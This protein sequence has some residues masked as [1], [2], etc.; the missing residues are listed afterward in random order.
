MTLPACSRC[1]SHGS[2]RGR[3]AMSLPLCEAVSVTLSLGQSLSRPQSCLSEAL[4]TQCPVAPGGAAR[5]L[6]VAGHPCRL[7]FVTWPLLCVP[8]PTCPSYRTP[9]L[10]AGPHMTSF[11]LHGICNDPVSNKVPCTVPGPE[12]HPAHGWLA[13]RPPHVRA[14]SA[15]LSTSGLR[16]SSSDP[17]LVSHPLLLPLLLSFKQRPPLHVT[18]LVQTSRPTPH[19]G[20]TWTCPGGAALW[21][22][23][24]QGLQSPPFTQVV[25]FVATD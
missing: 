7:A 1:L 19:G 6:S 10:G 3:G 22:P 11:Q 24:A 25:C 21:P 18:G 20:L 4:Q 8:G 17:L 23:V 13:Q 2:Y 16:F 15:R 14:G 5:P 9:A 12:L